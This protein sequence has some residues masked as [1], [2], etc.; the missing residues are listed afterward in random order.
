[1][2]SSRLGYDPEN[3]ENWKELYDQIGV[4]HIRKEGFLKFVEQYHSSQVV[5]S[6][7]AS[8]NSIAK[9]FVPLASEASGGSSPYTVVKLFYKKLFYPEDTDDE[10]RQLLLS[11]INNASANA[12]IKKRMQ[13]LKQQGI[14][15]INDVHI[16]IARRYRAEA[17]IGLDKANIPTI[18]FQAP[19][20]E[21][22]TV[23]AKAA[24]RLHFLNQFLEEVRIK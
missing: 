1:M 14:F 18:W 12:N 2:I 17:R 4:Y 9:K 10:R 6:E 3:S 13:F 23:D 15:W 16:S 19:S 8:L 5:K 7:K 20:A 22:L 11:F 24:L 21:A